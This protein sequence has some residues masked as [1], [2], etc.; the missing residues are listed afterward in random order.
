MPQKIYRQEALDRLSSPDQFDQLM[1]LTSP[2]AWIA[3][4]AA[5]L[6]L[7]A[8]A[9]W[10]VFGTITVSV[11]GEGLFTRPGGVRLVSAPDNG[12][13]RAVS[14]EVGQKVQ[15][16]Q[17]LLRIASSMGGET[18][19][20]VASPIA[21]RILAVSVRVND[22][23]KQ[24]ATLITL[25]PLEAALEAILFVP[26][27]E[28]AY[29]IKP[30]NS[31]R[32]LRGSGKGGKGFAVYGTVRSASR[33]PIDGETLLRVLQSESWVDQVSRSGP[34]LQVVVELEDEPAPPAEEELPELYSGAP[35]HAHIVVQRK[36]PI[37]LVLPFFGV[38]A[39][40]GHE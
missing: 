14:V 7:V 38:L 18:A 35:C 4:G 1:P 11:D 30:G 33:Y 22:N 5:G 28:D 17:P 36:R 13:V 26:A 23:V 39:R 34:C 40:L 12:R 21:G 32:L 19:Q 20:E 31:V 2:R 10:A 3:L 16:G 25:E 24:G 37:S 6:L 8:A 9:L 15:K 29:L 27:S